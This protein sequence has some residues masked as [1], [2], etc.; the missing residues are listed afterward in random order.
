MLAERADEV[1]GKLLALVDVAADLA[2]PAVL[3]LEL[4]G[5]R[6]DIGEIVGVGHGRH[7]GELPRLGDVGDEERV[8]LKL[9]GLR[10]PGR[11][12]GVRAVRQIVDTVGRAGH[13]LHAGKLVDVA[14]GL[15]AIVLE[16]CERRVVRENGDVE[17]PGLFDH[18][19]RIIRLVD[20]DGDALG[21][22]SQLRDRVDDAAVVLCAVAG[23]QDEQ[24]VGQGEHRVLLDRG[25]RGV[26]RGLVLRHGVHDSLGQRVHRLE[27]G[28]LEAG[29]DGDRLVEDRAVFQL[30]ELCTHQPAR[31]R[32]PGAIF[33]EGDGAVLEVVVDDVV[34]EIFHV[35]E[36]AGVVRRGE[37]DKVA[38][39]EAFGDDLARMRRGDVVDLDVADAEVGQLPGQNIRGSLGIAVDGGVG[40][41]DGV[42]FGRIG[43]P[44]DVF[45]DEPADVLAPDRAV[46]RADRLDLDRRGLFQQSLY[47][48]AVFADDVGIVAPRIVEPL[49]LEVDLV[50][51][52]VAAQ[53]AKRAKGVGGEEG[54]RRGI[55]GHHDL[56]PVYHR[57]HD[58][59][60]GVFAGA[61][62]IH[63][64]DEVNAA[65]DVEGEEVLHHLRGLLIADE[66]DLWI[67]EH[68]GLDRGGVVRLHVV[69]NE[70]VQL[71]AVQH[72]RQI[73]KE[74]GRDGVVDRVEQDGLFVQN[75]V[76]IVAHAARDGID[77]FEQRQPPVV[78]A[79]PVEIL[80]HFFHTVHGK[81]LLN[82]A[83]LS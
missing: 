14:A 73:F 49:G 65:V 18:V 10:D 34:D 17:Y 15:E 39:T 55:I 19:V 80:G 23:R 50:G 79:D 36:H 11:N 29:L 5:L 12:K 61:E 60:E 42:L 7:V 2:D 21:G 9:D 74:D 58:E 20:G 26:Y 6:L 68:D 66:R 51:I 48:C 33:N 70:I 64:G 4:G 45:V 22:I 27:L 59:R 81:A 28:F 46:Q 13:A 1:C 71:A 75:N 8:R 37:E 78:A 43:R 31:R 16:H 77:V 76:G 24:A 69:D 44:V 62:R 83:L 54:L 63:L 57:G 82:I 52:E 30:R 56:G 25:V 72:V 53:R 41:D 35:H 3:L 47:L 40:D 32:R 67:A 38:R